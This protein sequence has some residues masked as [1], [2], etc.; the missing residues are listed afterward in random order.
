MVIDVD[1]RWLVALLLC[2][3]RISAVLMLAPILSAIGV[4]SRIRIVLTLALALGLVTGLHLPY[5]HLPTDISPLLGMAV[6]EIVLGA[7][8]A[9]GIFAA[10][11]AFHFAG[12][13]LDIQIGFNIA[14]VFDP[15][16]HSQAPLLASL[17]SLVAALLFF[18]L[19][20]HHALIRGIAWSLERVP[21]GMAFPV[22]DPAL[23]IRQFGTLF[24]F[25][26]LLAAPVLFVLFLVEISLGVLSRTLPQLNLFLLSPPIKI[27]IGLCVLASVAG[28]FQTVASKIFGGLFHYWEAIL[29]G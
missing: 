15:V 17:F 13:A 28:Q 29:N 5:H 19:E 12:S 7:V 21:L 6:Q 8:L 10:F 27:V 11:A 3:L 26:L 16:T 25:G 23:I 22:S 20:G 14:N 4:P 9:F 1:I 2:S 18:L 24:G